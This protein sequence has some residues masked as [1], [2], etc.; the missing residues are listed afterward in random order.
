M[1]QS[2]G[3]IA[4]FLFCLLCCTTAC[5]HSFRVFKN[6]IERAALRQGI[7]TKTIHRYLSPIPAPKNIRKTKQVKTATRIQH[8]TTDFKRYMARR[9]SIRMNRAGKKRFNQHHT[10]LKKIKRRFGVPGGILVA[11]WGLESD[12][13]LIQGRYPL[14]TS[15]AYLAYEKQFRSDF[16]RKQLIAAL[17]IVDR[18]KVIQ[19]ELRSTFDGGMGQAQFEPVS[20]LHYAVDFDRDHFAN[21]WTSHADALASMANYLA[22]NGWQPSLHWGWRA[23]VPA[24]FNLKRAGKRHRHPVS[25]WRK[26]GVTLYDGSPLPSVSG[27]TG[28]ILPAGAKGPAY[29]VTKN[30]FVLLR[31]NNTIYETLAVGLF[32]DRLDQEL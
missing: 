9:V 5:A 29:F 16:F 1:R 24:K 32:S 26:K 11:L 6:E 27:D 18:P 13:G 4:L 12:F 8:R 22:R 14:M 2:A 19:Q 17:R 15:L 3:Y 30:Y 20:Y 7:S 28:V 23:K 21:I 31:W 10:L 25:Y